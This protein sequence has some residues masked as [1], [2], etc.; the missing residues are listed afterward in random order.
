[1]ID[2]W[3][4]EVNDRDMKSLYW[5]VSYGKELYTFILNKE[6]VSVFLFYFYK[7]Q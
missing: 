3:H 7:L 2:L 1:M 5:S 6:E 4:K